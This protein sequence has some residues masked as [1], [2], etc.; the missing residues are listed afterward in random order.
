MTL[1]GYG[2]IVSKTWADSPEHPNIDGGDTLAETGRIYFLKKLCNIADTLMP[3][4]RAIDLLRDDKFQLRRHPDTWNNPKDVS[5]DQLDPMIM[6]M[7]LYAYLPPPQHLFY[8]NGDIASPEHLSH[9]NRPRWYV[10]I[11]DLFMLL[12]TLIICFLYPKKVENDLNHIVSL[13][14]AERF[15]PTRIS[16]LAAETYLRH[17]DYQLALATYYQPFTGNNDLIKYYLAGL[18][19]LDEAQMGDSKKQV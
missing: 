2:L 3:F 10:L 12:N 16:K 15:G 14:F 8:P 13:C 9:F 18:K 17:R 4:Y 7:K 5:R 6:C 11:A 19:W 1:D